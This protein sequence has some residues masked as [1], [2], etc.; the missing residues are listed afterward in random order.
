MIDPVIGWI[1]IHTV[2]SAQ[3]DL[4]A[5]QVELAWLMH[6]P[7]SCKE[8]LDRENEFLAEFRE[9]V[10]NDY[11]IT[12]NPIT[13][14][15]LQVNAI[16]ERVHQ[17]IGNIICTFKVQ[18]MVLDDKNP[19]DAILSSNT[20]AIRATVHTTMQYTPAHSIIT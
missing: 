20:S 19:W 14:R 9:R 2:P 8:I 12:V 16:L 15:N 3:E 6:Y 11:S 10:I 17:T 13:S 5:N 4:M 1:E 18:T 7:L